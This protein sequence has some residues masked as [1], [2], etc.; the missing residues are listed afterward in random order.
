MI[1]ATDVFDFQA[2]MAD[3]KA[4]A[5][6]NKHRPADVG[7]MARVDVSTLR[8]WYKDDPRWGLSLHVVVRLSVYADLD[9]NKYTLVTNEG[10]WLQ[11]KKTK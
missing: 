5:E 9:L 7:H 11:R 3:V 6:R 10:G 4:Y 2:F 1:S 8:E